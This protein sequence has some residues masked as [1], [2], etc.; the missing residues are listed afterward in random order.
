MAKYKRPNY[1][2]LA[3]SLAAAVTAI[4]ALAVSIWQ[5]VETRRHNRLSVVPHLTYYVTFATMDQNVG[6]K[7]SNNGIGPA[8]VT[9]FAIYVDGEQMNDIGAGG[10][11]SAIEKLGLDESWVTFHWL[12]PNGAIRVGETVWLLA[13]SPEDQNE[14]RVHMLENAIPRLRIHID[15]K[16]IYGDWFAVEVEGV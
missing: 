8:V 11:H 14:D 12:D 6:I 4:A 5:G 9:T 13:I 16:S 15:Y 10:W 7:L 3:V 1:M 2:E